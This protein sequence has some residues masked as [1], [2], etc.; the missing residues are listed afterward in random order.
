MAKRQQVAE[1]LR[2]RI[3]AREFKVGDKLPGVVDLSNH[4][5]CSLEIARQALWV[6]HEEGFVRKPQ[7][8]LATKVIASPEPAQRGAREL[9]AEVQDAVRCLEA[10]LE[11]LAAALPD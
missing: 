7:Q 1:D 8:G 4:Y 11:A 2:R 6:L 3:E 9:L 5:E 10:K